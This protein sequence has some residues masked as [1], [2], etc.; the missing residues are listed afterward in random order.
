[1]SLL[2][3]LLFHHPRGQC[4]LT[5]QEAKAA[6]YPLLINGDPKLDLA[7]VDFPD[8]PIVLDC[9]STQWLHPNLQAGSPVPRSK[10][11]LPYFRSWILLKVTEICPNSQKSQTPSTRCPTRAMR[12]SATL[13]STRTL[14]PNRTRS[15]TPS[16]HS[17][18]K[19]LPNACPGCPIMAVLGIVCSKM[20]RHLPIMYLFI[21]ACLKRYA[22]WICRYTDDSVQ[23]LTW[24]SLQYLPSDAISTTN[25]WSN[26][27][28]LLEVDIRETFRSIGTILIFIS[29]VMAMLQF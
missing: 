12:L 29:W 3:L 10:R 18:L 17:W 13:T 1:M 16:I 28:R 22:C 8:Y 9:K 24:F 27:R 23:V 25:L 4:S 11:P 7:D 14:R 21:N 20:P 26:A 2:H 15:P 6:S 19:S 5:I